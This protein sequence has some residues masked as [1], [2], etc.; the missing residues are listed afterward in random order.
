MPESPSFTYSRPA[1]RTL[2]IL[3]LRVG[4][5]IETFNGEV[6]LVPGRLYG[7]GFDGLDV[8]S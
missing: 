4:A 3:D 2:A 8:S 5:Y 7:Y 6:S 1:R